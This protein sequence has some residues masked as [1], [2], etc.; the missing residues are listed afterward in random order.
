VVICVLAGVLGGAYW[1]NRTSDMQGNMQTALLYP[2]DFRPLPKFT[3][4]GQTGDFQD[5]D[6]KDKWSLIFFGYTSCPDVCPNTLQ[7]MQQV[8][9]QL[10]DNA[11]MQYVMVSVDPDRDTPQRLHDYTTYFNPAFLGLTAEKKILDYALFQAP[12]ISDEIVAD[13]AAMQKS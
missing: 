3:L 2:E 12:H 4:Q 7:V 13:L 9:E 10:G 6:L 1:F 11:N 5:A 8:S